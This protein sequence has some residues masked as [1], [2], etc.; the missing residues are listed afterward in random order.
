MDR[1]AASSAMSAAAEVLVA[2]RRAGLRRGETGEVVQYTTTASR[3]GAYVGAIPHWL[4]FTPLRKHGP[5]GAGWSSG[6]RASAPIAAILGIVIG[7]WMYSPSKRYR[8]AGAA[9]SIPYRGQKRWHTIF[10]LIF[11]LG[12]ATWAF[13]GMLSMDPFPSRR[14]QPAAGAAAAAAAIPQALRGAVAAGGVCG[15]AS[16][17]GAGADRRSL[18]VKELELTSFAGEPVYLATLGGGDTRV[19]PLGG[20]AA[21]RV[22]SAADHR[23]RDEGG[24]PAAAWPRSALLEQ[25]DAYYLDRRRQ[26]P[27]PVILARL[28]DADRH[29]LLHRSRRRRASSAPTPR[30]AG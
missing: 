27:L 26:R 24:G 2:R 3:L 13:S 16:A 5:N 29:A 20:S 18:P 30:A 28:N 22:R 4:Y 9:T 17:R 11:G 14:R 23:R 21:S 12:A 25:Y 19:V 10:G 15:Q 8:N 6:P 1:P 7:I